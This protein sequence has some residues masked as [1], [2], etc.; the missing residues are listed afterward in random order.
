MDRMLIDWLVYESNRLGRKGLKVYQWIAPKSATQDWKGTWV[1]GPDKRGSA[2][3]FHD[4]D[5]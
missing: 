2:A 5:Y 1:V 3:E 4:T